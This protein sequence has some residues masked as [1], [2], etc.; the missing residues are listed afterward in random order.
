MTKDATIYQ[1]TEQGLEDLK[2]EIWNL[3]DIER[4][5]IVIREGEKPALIVQYKHTNAVTK[6]LTL[7]N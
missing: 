5:G 2:A 7:L 6:V 4:I 1:I 3:N